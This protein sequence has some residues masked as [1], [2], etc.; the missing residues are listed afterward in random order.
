SRGS[1]P[2]GKG[3]APTPKPGAPGK[4]T[5]PGGGA[6]RSCAEYRHD[7]AQPQEREPH[8]DEDHDDF[9]RPPAETE[10]FRGDRAQP[11]RSMNGHRHHEDDIKRGPR[12]VAARAP[13]DFRGA[14]PPAHRVDDR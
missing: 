1:A 3:R 5:T 7:R 4:P 9:R 13:E 8:A 14:E 10:P 2:A 12:D 6:P 11:D